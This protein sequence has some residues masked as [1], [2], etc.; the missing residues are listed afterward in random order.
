MFDVA[1]DIR[2]GSPTFGKWVGFV[3]SG[4]NFLQLWIP[5]GFA[6]GF[7]VLSERVHV[8][9][10]CSDFYDPGYELGIAWNDPQ[11]GITWPIQDPVLSPK[12]ASALPLAERLPDLPVYG[13]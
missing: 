11:I 3:L 13:P 1:V 5:G 10:K 9:Y 12:D 8:E 2:R 7:C 6:H 4:E